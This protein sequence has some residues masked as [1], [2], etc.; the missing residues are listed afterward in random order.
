VQIEIRSLTAA[1]A[2]VFHA[3]RL[4]GLKESPEAFGSTYEEDLELSVDVVAQ[5]IEPAHTP[6]ARI[7]LGAFR[8]DTLIGVVG[9][10]QAP[11]R[12]L[13]HTA[14]IWGMYVAPEAR[15]H[16][17]ARRLLD[18]IIAQ[19]RAWP[20][21]HRITLSVVDRAAAARELYA[22]AGFEMFGHEADAFRQN[23]VSDA[24]EHLALRL[25]SPSA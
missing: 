19:A 22:S 17:V 7:V 1:D 10:F 2:P 15:G 3:L 23:G 13:R 5:R 21:V 14:S 25:D 6:A 20:G 4:R 24:V 11:K 8:D 9:C 16:G 18:A 12:K